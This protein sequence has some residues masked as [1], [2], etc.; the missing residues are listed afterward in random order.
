MYRIAILGC[1]NS[2]ATH[3]LK[4]LSEGKYPDVKVVGIF[5]EETDA[6]EKLS[7]RFS[8]PILPAY[9]APVKEV[10]GVM[11]TARHGDNHYKYAKPY[12]SRGIPMFIDKPITCS[13]EEAVAFMRDAKANGVRLCGGSLCATLEETLKLKAAREGGALGEIRGGHVTAPIQLTSVYGGATFYAQHLIEI[14]T[15]IFGESVTAVCAKAEK[16]SLSFL[17]SYE[18]GFNVTGQYVEKGKYYTASVYGSE[19]MQ[20]ETLTVTGGN[21][22]DEMYALLCGGE[23]QKSY[24]SFIYPV[25]VMNAILRSAESGAWEAVREIRL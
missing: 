10:D 9:D 14:M 22:M 13:E 23:M 12:L 20:A 8:V 17:A 3:F 21:F 1:E 19:S 24:E 18:D 5:S 25:F 11:I 2:H 15:A 7:E 6:A 4:V 16:T